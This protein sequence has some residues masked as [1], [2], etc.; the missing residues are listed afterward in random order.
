[1]R[2]AGISRSA[3]AR[4]GGHCDSGGQTERSVTITTREINARQ[5]AE[6]RRDTEEA[7][8]ATERDFRTLFDLPGSGN[9]IADARSGRFLRV[10]RRFGEITGYSEDDLR[11]LTLHALTHP[12]DVERHRAGWSAAVR[13]RAGVLS[14]ETRY[15]RKSGSVVWIHTSATLVRDRYGEPLHAIGAIRDVTDHHRAVEELAEARRALASAEA[16]GAERERRRIGQALHDD[17]CQQLLGAALAAKVLGSRLAPGSPLAT[18]ADALAE[19]INSAVRQARDTVQQ[20][21]PA[22]EAA[23]NPAPDA[24]T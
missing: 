3:T 19:L 16:G 20:L 9:F 8:R 22:E 17:L 6:K 1:M 14:I 15:M 11:F 21:N 12:D 24:S 18:D 10:N 13:E 23:Q 2:S 7:L 4:S 5:E